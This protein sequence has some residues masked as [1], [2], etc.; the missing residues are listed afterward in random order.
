MEYAKIRE[1]R[2]RVEK[3][4]QQINNKSGGRKEDKN[5][6]RCKFLNRQ[7]QMKRSEGER[8]KEFKCEIVTN[9]KTQLF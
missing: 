9:I 1:D 3:V 8:K 4:G 5:R 6:K 7:R 2:G